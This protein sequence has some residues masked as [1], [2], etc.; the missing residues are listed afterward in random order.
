MTR[1]LATT[2]HHTEDDMQTLCEIR[3]TDGEIFTL[4]REHGQMWLTFQMDADDTKPCD[5]IEV[6]AELLIALASAASG[7]PI[8]GTRH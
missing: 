6:S 2:T 5:T 4:F 7:M 3:T 1:T 8:T